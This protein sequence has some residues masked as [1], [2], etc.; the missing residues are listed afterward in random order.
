MFV[1]GLWVEWAKSRARAQ[2]WSEEVVL[3]AEEMHRVLWFLKWKATWWTNQRDLRSDVR[4]DIQEGLTAYS[5]KQSATLLG[6][7]MKF[8][9]KWYEIL[10]E[11]GLSVEWPEEFLPSCSAIIA[12]NNPL[13]VMQDDDPLIIDDDLF[14]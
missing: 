1:I 8:A 9:N 10:V 4:S 14:E 12:R 11:N 3:L 2:R 6:M 5:A 13:Q 7:G